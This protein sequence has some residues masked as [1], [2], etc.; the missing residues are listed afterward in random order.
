MAGKG[1]KKRKIGSGKM[2]SPQF[3]GGDPFKKEIYGFPPKTL[4]E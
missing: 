3:A 4:R 2:S 1:C